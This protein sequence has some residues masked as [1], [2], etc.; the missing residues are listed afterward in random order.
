MK[1]IPKRNFLFKQIED[2]EGN[3]KDVVAKKGV[4]IEMTTEEIKR[5]A[6]DI[7][8]LPEKGPLSTKKK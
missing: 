5:F 8:G 4:A 7:E 3:T 2:G 6:A 1:V